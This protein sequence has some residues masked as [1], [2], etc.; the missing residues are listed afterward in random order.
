MQSPFFVYQRQV[1]ILFDHELPE[2]LIKIKSVPI[3]IDD[4]LALLCWFS[5]KFKNFLFFQFRLSFTVLGRYFC[6]FVCSIFPSL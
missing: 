2:L 3:L 4:S 5:L 1:I 6:S